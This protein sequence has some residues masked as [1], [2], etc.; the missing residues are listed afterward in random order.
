MM[1]FSKFIAHQGRLNETGAIEPGELEQG[2]QTRQFQD[3]KIAAV[4]LRATMSFQERLDRMSEFS[5][6]LAEL[7]EGDI[8][9]T[10]FWMSLTE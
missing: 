3:F 2:I 1:K 4:S 7:D 6:Y 8:M 5:R 9:V 10:A